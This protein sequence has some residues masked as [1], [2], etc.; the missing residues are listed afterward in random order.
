MMSNVVPNVRF[1]GV[2]I[3]KKFVSL[4]QEGGWTIKVGVRWSLG[5][6]ETPY[7]ALETGQ[8]ETV[9]NT[10]TLLKR[11]GKGTTDTLPLRADDL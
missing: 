7:A 10:S 1:R 3:D 8:V 9:M 2:L 4:E 11:A 6:F 5:G